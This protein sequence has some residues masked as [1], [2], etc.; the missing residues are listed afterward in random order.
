M[1]GYGQVVTG[2]TFL[3]AA[4]VVVFL[5]LVLRRYLAERSKAQRDERDAAT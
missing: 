2:T 3:A 5:I 4:I 1:I